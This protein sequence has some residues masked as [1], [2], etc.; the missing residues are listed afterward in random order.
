IEADRRRVGEEQRVDDLFLAD[1]IVGEALDDGAGE[2]ELAAVD[3]AVGKDRATKN[4]VSRIEHAPPLAGEAARIDFHVFRVHA[5]PAQ[6]VL[7]V[8]LRRRSQ[9]REDVLQDDARREDPPRNAPPSR[10]QVD[11]EFLLRTGG[12]AGGAADE[13]HVTGPG[14]EDV[15]AQ[16][17]NTL[18]GLDASSAAIRAEYVV[19]SGLRAHGHSGGNWNSV[20]GILSVL[21]FPS[22][23]GW[24]VT[25]NV[26]YVTP[27]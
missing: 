25:S 11:P 16:D 2:V 20:A 22:A 6:R 3:S 27:S 4:R 18:G 14:E 19:G 12:D 21:A 1:P 10:E 24:R 17:P 15:P 26:V 23:T 5:G 9:D 13:R 7:E 8:S